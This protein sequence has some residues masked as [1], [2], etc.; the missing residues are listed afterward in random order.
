MPSEI[1]QRTHLHEKEAVD[2]NAISPYN[3]EMMI[4]FAT[5][6]TRSFIRML[7]RAE[8]Q[9]RL[10]RPAAPRRNGYKPFPR[11]V[12]VSTRVFFSD[13]DG[14]MPAAGK[15]CSPLPLIFAGHDVTYHMARTPFTSLRD[16]AP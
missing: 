6:A 10:S 3:A 14:L 16:D 5:I 15:A 1:C 8:W 7:T 2:A 12:A 9:G 13:D 4:S 11:D